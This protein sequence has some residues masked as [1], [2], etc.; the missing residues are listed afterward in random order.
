[1]ELF[2]GHL[3]GQV[4]D[5]K[6]LL[7][8]EGVL[9][10]LLGLVLAFLLLLSLD[11]VV[12]CVTLLRHLSGCL[13]YRAFAVDHE[14]LKLIVPRLFLLLRARALAHQLEELSELGLFGLDFMLLRA[15]HTLVAVALLASTQLAFG[16]EHALIRG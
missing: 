5:V 15:G 14:L 11:S 7:I 12:S 1:M 9:Q 16:L 8:N 3:I 13:L 2:F 10:T 4:H 6:P